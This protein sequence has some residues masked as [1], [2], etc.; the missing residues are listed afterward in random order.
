MLPDFEEMMSVA[1]SLNNAIR[2]KYVFPAKPDWL[3]KK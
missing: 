1:E 2:V 3:I